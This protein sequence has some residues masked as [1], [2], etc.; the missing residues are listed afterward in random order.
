MRKIVKPNITI[1]IM[2]K[3]NVNFFLQNFKFHFLRSCLKIIFD[4]L[5]P[6]LHFLINFY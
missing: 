2:K 4:C 6:L 3:N 5:I 1:L